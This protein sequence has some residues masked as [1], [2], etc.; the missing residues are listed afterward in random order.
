VVC[1]SIAAWALW[2]LGYPDQG[3]ARSHDALL[4][5]QQ[6][7]H[8][9]SLGFALGWAAVVHQYRGEV[10]AAQARA[11]AV[12]SLAT[13]QGWPFFRAFGALLR[14]WALAHQGQTQEGIEGL[15]Q[16]LI[17][18]HGSGV[19]IARLYFRARSQGSNPWPTQVMAL[20]VSLP[21]HF[22]LDPIAHLRYKRPSV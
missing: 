3:L 21:E 15:R 22:P 16:G 20:G 17:G 7:A 14:G 1:Y 8:P 11:E 2:S 19:E 12:M 5:A 9:F 18:L 10:P 4:L 6:R 13:E